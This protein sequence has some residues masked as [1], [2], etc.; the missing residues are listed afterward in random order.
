[1]LL[2]PNNDAAN[3]AADT[4]SAEQA[5]QN[6]TTRNQWQLYASHRQHLV[7]LIVPDS[8][9]QGRI[10]VLG[11]G[12]CNDLDLK[13]LCDVY[14]EVHLVDLDPAA[15]DAAVERQPVGDRSKIHLHAPFDLTGIADIASR[16]T[17]TSPPT[18]HQLASAI[19]RLAQPPQSPWGRLET[20]RSPCVL[21]QLIHPIRDALRDHGG[22]PPSHPIRSAIRKALRQRHLRMLAACT[23][24]GGKAVL[25]V[26]VISSKRHC[27]LARIPEDRLDSFM[28]T[29]ISNGGHFSGVEPAALTAAWRFDQVLSRAF[30]E[31]RFSAPWLWHLG[32][33]KSFLVYVATFST[34]AQ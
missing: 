32:L 20:V 21:T 28:R 1:M 19:H 17:N 16:W 14:R 5:R 8:P 33:R 3:G 18:L 9:R 10:C 12:N 15:L 4:I 31:P 25:A 6:R 29:S 2:L 22:L 23:A 30:A 13:W 34:A 11:A 24:P 7:R 27:D 26:D